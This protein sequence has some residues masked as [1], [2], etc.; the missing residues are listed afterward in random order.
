MLSLVFIKS[1]GSR[2]S[3]H[4]DLVRK[5][6]QLE[7][8]I[9]WMC[10]LPTLSSGLVSCTVVAFFGGPQQKQPGGQPHAEQKA[11]FRLGLLWRLS[12]NCAL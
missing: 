2:R 6:M 4:K 12:I 7:S 3:R 5:Q 11:D 1:L 10:L 8:D 9:F